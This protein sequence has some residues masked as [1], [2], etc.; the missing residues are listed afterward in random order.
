[1]GNQQGLPQ[2]PPES[3]AQFVHAPTALAMNPGCGYRT[4]HLRQAT[5][6]ESHPGL[7]APNSPLPQFA[8]R[9]SQL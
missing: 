3:L 8:Y 9:D 6:A 7:F 4:R 1:M 5:C 2:S